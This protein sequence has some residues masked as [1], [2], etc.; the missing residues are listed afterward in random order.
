MI[1][2]SFGW[3]LVEHCDFCLRVQ[4][5]DTHLLTDG[6]HQP[7]V[8]CMLL[9]TPE[10]QPFLVMMA[11]CLL[12]L[13]NQLQKKWRSFSPVCIVL[14]RLFQSG[15]EQKTREEEIFLKTSYDMLPVLC[16]F[17]RINNCF[18]NKIDQKMETILCIFQFLPIDS[19]NLF[20]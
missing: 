5:E 15:L 8:I 17:T 4:L 18:L 12:V 1:L 19:N 11:L 2:P 6:H 9:S 7:I 20:N 3:D 16:F 13:V 14:I 10:L